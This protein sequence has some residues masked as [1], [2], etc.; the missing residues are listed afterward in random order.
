MLEISA[1]L[2]LGAL[3]GIV[4]SF[5][6]IGGGTI[7]VPTLYALYPSLSPIEVIYCS[8][9]TVFL[10]CS[11][12]VGQF[13]IKKMTPPK[14]LIMVIVAGTLL[15]GSLGPLSVN[16]FSQDT[17]KKIFAFTLL[18]MAARVMLSSKAVQEGTTVVMR[19]KLLSFLI[20]SAG[21]FVAAI[22]GIGGGVI[23]TPSFYHFLKLS[24]KVVTAYSNVAMASGSLIAAIN[25][26]PKLPHAPMAYIKYWPII[27][28][29]AL[30]SSPLGVKINLKVSDTNK[31]RILFMTLIILGLK[32]LFFS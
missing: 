1:L 9:M 2:I 31:R 6:G 27:F 24:P 29:G 15:G 8:L 12:N 32:M 25:Y 7:I 26:I 16:L 14:T 28:L 22:T 17:L 10:S 30:I 20:A 5:L 21:S 13:A 3:I 18:I 23:F 19:P 4:S 11:L